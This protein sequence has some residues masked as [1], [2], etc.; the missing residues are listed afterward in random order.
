M[1]EA[2]HPWPS[3]PLP[4][5]L[6]AEEEDYG[7]S[8]AAETPEP[9]EFKNIVG[10]FGGYT[11]ER[12]EGGG[13]VGLEYERRLN[14]WLGFGAFGEVIAG[15]HPASVF[16]AG[17]YLRPTEKFAFVVMPGVEF[18]RGETGRF[19]TRLGV[20]YDLWQSGR[21][22]VVPGAYVDLFRGS[23]AFVVGL[24]LAWEF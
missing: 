8:P 4:A 5:A 7:G 19:M 9:E 10:V 18:E 6:L 2:V 1:P 3:D 21:T 24:S 14:P 20:I 13:T 23:A 12:N 16:G 22:I 17:V 11:T 15:S